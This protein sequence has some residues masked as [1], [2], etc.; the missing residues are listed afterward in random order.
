[1]LLRYTTNTVGQQKKHSVVAAMLMSPVSSF[2]PVPA[3]SRCRPAGR[4]QKDTDDARRRSTRVDHTDC[5]LHDTRSTP[6]SAAYE[7]M[8]ASA[9][10]LNTSSP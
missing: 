10:N 3:D 1:M 9:R 6:A 4:R 7:N 2:S 5:P 8:T